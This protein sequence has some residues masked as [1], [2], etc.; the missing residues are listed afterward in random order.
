[1]PRPKSIPR[2]VAGAPTVIDRTADCPL[3]HCLQTHVQTMHRS[4]NA[5]STASRTIARAKGAC[6]AR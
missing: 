4:R 1:L 5:T 3:Y 6:R 2:D